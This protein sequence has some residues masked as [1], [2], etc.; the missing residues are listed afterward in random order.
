[1]ANCAGNSPV[2]SEFPH[3]GQWRGALMF[4]LICAC[5]DGWVNN[6]EV[7]DLR[8]H[9]DYY[10]VTVMLIKIAVALQTT[11]PNTFHWHKVVVFGIHLWLKLVPECPVDDKSVFVHVMIW[12]R[13]TDKSLT[14]PM[15]TKFAY[16][17]MS[18]PSSISYMFRVASILHTQCDKPPNT[19][20]FALPP[21][22][23]NAYC[24]FTDKFVKIWYQKQRNFWMM[25]MSK[26]MIMIIT[27]KYIRSYYQISLVMYIFANISG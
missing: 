14:E 16:A 1:M 24:Y 4:S 27:Y 3:K 7:G 17:S 21:C 19:Y 15:L 10:D 11:Y 6:R 9:R 22:S 18:Y 25:T 20:V 5:M 26:I 12:C 13:P 2:P 23:I 8:R